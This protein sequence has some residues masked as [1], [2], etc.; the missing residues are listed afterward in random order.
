VIA[1]VEQFPGIFG[2]IVINA[3]W[4]QMQTSSV[5]SVDFSAVDAALASVRTYNSANPSAPLGVK[6]R[7]Y[8]GNSAPEWAKELSGGPVTIYRNPGGC[9][10]VAD[11]CPLTIGLFWTTPYITAWRAFQA[12]VAAK[13]DSEPLIRAVAVTSCASQTDEPFVPTTGPVSKK[14]LENAPVPYTDAKE[15]ACLT[16]AITDYA[17]WTQSDIDFTFNTYSKIT[18]GTDPAFTTSVMNLCRST[19]GARCVLDNHALE[20]PPYSADAGVYSNIEA[21]AGLVNFQTQSPE[22]MGCLWQETIAQGI[23]FGARAI[24]IWPETKY[25]G[26]DSLSVPDV[27]SLASQFV[28]PIPVST[29]TPLPTPCSGFH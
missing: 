16:G 1:N 13:Y 14:N 10:G 20:S 18:G 26:F 29:A 4:S 21:A 27:Q 7:I 9:D 22:A 2:G 23:A 6:L 17:A 28:S 3:T 11:S 5:G 8:G 24:E 15:Q 25:Q 19:I 12:Q